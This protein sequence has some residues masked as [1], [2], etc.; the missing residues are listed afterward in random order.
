[1]AYEPSE[2]FFAAVML[3]SPETL[4]A[5]LKNDTSLRK[6]YKT[7]LQN[8]Q[9]TKGKKLAPVIFADETQRTNFLSKVELADEKKDPSARAGNLKVL[10]N[11]VQAISAA[12]AMKDRVNTDG[13]GYQ[14][15]KVFMTGNTWPDEIDF[16]RVEIDNWQDYNSTDIMLYYTNRK[17]GPK[18]YGVSLKKKPNPTSDDPTLI[19]KVFDTFINGDALGPLRKE[20]SNAKE[21]H[22]TNIVISAVNN[23]V[24]FPQHIKKT[25]TAFIGGDAGKDLEAVEKMIMD[26]EKKIPKEKNAKNLTKLKSDLTKY[27]KERTS[28]NN[29]IER[30]WTQ[31]STSS[32]G[33][34]EL[35]ECNHIDKS[36]LFKPG[37]TAAYARY[38]NVKGSGAFWQSNPKGYWDLSK[39]QMQSEGAMRKYV[40]KQLGDRQAGLF[41]KYIKIM[42]TYSEQFGNA[43]LS[44]ILKTKLEKV[45]TDVI[46]YNKS[47]LVRKVSFGFFLVTGNGTINSKGITY[48]KGEAKSLQTILCGLSDIENMKGIKGKP[49]V[50]TQR[51]KM[52]KGKT[53]D[54]DQAEDKES[55]AAK[56]YLTLQRGTFPI[57]NLELRFKG[58][59]MQQPQFQAFITTQYDTLLKQNC[60]GK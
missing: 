8:S 33:R 24:I 32:A 57:L 41:S 56:V 4:E 38:I 14:T 6:F 12:L 2:I 53:S 16:M 58:D 51:S 25:S 21:Q 17:N 60:K 23:R 59:F 3:E 52:I 43:L 15:P 37:V 34:K 48:A 45:I 47:P 5:A 44:I 9:A 28:L 46:R 1:M 50:I 30:D 19:N 27:K 20:L 49:Y 7:A 13:Y 36:R 39:A 29:K 42:N 31:W 26:L 22:F 35:F 10:T 11:L 55:E 40:N 18:Y 54:G